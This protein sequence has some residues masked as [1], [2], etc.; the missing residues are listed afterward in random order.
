MLTLRC[1]RTDEEKKNIQRPCPSWTVQWGRNP[2]EIKTLTAGKTKGST[3]HTAT[4]FSTFPGSFLGDLATRRMF[5]L[6]NGVCVKLYLMWPVMCN[7]VS[8]LDTWG[9]HVSVCSFSNRTV[10]LTRSKT[11]HIYLK[12][13]RM[14]TLNFCS[15]LCSPF[16]FLIYVLLI[17]LLFHS[18]AN[19]KSKAS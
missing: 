9:N 19:K 12:V 3:A 15:N 4:F 13:L 14:I 8:R 17:S 11:Y 10:L 6:V 1:T 18:I 16:F 5:L 7:L 2:A